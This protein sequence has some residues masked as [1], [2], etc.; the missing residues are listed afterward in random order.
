MGLEITITKILLARQNF[1]IIGIYR[2]PNS[3]RNWFE[4]L[5]NAI[6]DLIVYGKLILMG[7]LNCDLLSPTCPATK[8]L[9]TILELGNLVFKSEFEL[10]PTRITNTS[11]TCIDLIAVD[12]T[13]ELSRYA[14]ADFLLSDHFPVEADIEVVINKSISPVMRRSFK[15]VNFD[16]LGIKMAEIKLENIDDPLSFENQLQHWNDKFI[17]ILDDYMLLCMLILELIR[18]LI[19]LTKILGD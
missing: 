5:H 9:S 11:A 4:I 16:E 8:S 3:K 6:L 1:I 7:D 19:G 15:N 18:N 10:F 13:I 2:P 14:I 17:S 12:R